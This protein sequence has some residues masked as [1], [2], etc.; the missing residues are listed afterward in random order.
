MLLLWEAVKLGALTLKL[1]NELTFQHVRLSTEKLQGEGF[2]GHMVGKGEKGH[3]E[4]EIP[5]VSE[6]F[7]FVL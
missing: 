6:G 2:S 4:K 5:H 1:G 3:I 7:S